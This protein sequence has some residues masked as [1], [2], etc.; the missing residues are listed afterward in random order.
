MSVDFDIFWLIVSFS[1]PTAVELLV[2]IGVDSL[3]VHPISY[4]VFRSS[5]AYLMLA[6]ISTSS[7]STTD[8]TT[9]LIIAAIERSTLLFMLG[10]VEFNYFPKNNFPPTCL[11]SL[12]AER[13][14]AS[15]WTFKSICLPWN[16][17]FELGC[18]AQYSNNFRA[19]A[20]VAFFSFAWSDA[21]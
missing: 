8:D 13:Y 7:A 10:F 3:W 12:I 6:K 17:I 19:A 4:N 16:L 15:L 2:V 21:K 20:F 5:L 11:L 9:F 14:E 18:V 1:I